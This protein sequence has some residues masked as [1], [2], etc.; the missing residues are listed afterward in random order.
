[1]NAIELSITPAPTPTPR[2]RFRSPPSPSTLT[3]RQRYYE[4]NR[5]RIIERAKRYYQENKE[6]AKRLA[7][8]R[9]EEKKRQAKELAQKAEI[10]DILT[11]NKS[12][13][14]IIRDSSKLQQVKQQLSLIETHKP[15]VQKVDELQLELHKLKL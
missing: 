14:D 11:G 3:T 13:A 1:M 12:P 6:Y 8:E 15:C 7:K 4:K 10:L 2:T 5:E 9:Y